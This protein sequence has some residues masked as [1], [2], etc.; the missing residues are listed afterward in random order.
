MLPWVGTSELGIN[1]KCRCRVVICS[2]IPKILHA[3]FYKYRLLSIL[4]IVICP[5]HYILVC[6]IIAIWKRVWSSDDKCLQPGVCQYIL[7]FIK[8]IIRSSKMNIEANF[9]DE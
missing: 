5:L 6:L 2:P 7:L 1:W 4:V 8:T 3:L 9:I